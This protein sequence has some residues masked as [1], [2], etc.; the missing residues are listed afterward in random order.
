[1]GAT[2]SDGA[3]V[4]NMERLIQ[5][6]LG[7]HVALGVNDDLLSAG[8]VFK[9]EKVCRAAVAFHRASK[10]TTLSLVGR[11]GPRRHIATVVKTADD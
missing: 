10:K 4:A 3:V 1:M 6:D 2:D 7:V 11:Q 9:T 5:L 8:L